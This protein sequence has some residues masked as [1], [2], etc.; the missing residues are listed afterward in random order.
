MNKY[1]EMNIFGCYWIYSSPSLV[2]I[3]SDDSHHN[4][5]QTSIR[6]SEPIITQKMEVLHPMKA[7]QS[8]TT[9]FH[10]WASRDWH[11]WFLVWMSSS[12]HVTFF[13]NHSHCNVKHIPTEHPEVLITQQQIPAKPCLHWRTWGTDRL[14]LGL[15]RQI[16]EEF[17]CIL[18]KDRY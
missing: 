8:V 6:C 5:K 2:T 17:K 10:V 3:F 1:L 7:Y 4:I 18:H 15:C 14:V 12:S 13:P 9:N 11:F 16:E